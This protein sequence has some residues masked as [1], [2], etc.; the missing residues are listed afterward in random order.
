MEKGVMRV[1]MIISAAGAELSST[2][3]AAVGQNP[4]NL[5]QRQQTSTHCCARRDR[6]QPPELRV[7]SSTYHTNQLFFGLLLAVPAA[8]PPLVH[9]TEL[10]WVLATVAVA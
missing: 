6:L 1:G 3:A 2:A 7:L 5:G 9:A 4:E 8:P 10:D